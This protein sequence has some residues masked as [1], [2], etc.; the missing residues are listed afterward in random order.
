MNSPEY[1]R[2]VEIRGRYNK[3]RL[4]CGCYGFYVYDLEPKR[5][6]LN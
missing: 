5:N 4:L 2:V 1:V 3:S 6:L